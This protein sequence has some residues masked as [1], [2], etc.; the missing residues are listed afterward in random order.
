EAAINSQIYGGRPPCVDCGYC[1]GFGCPNHAKGSP[2]VTTLRSALLSGRCQLRFNAM[3]SRLVNDGGHVSAVEYFDGSGALQRARAGA[4]L[5]AAGPIE[6]PRLS[7]LAPT[8]SGGVLGNSSDQVG[9]NLM[10]HFQTN[11]N[12]FTPQRIHGQRGRAVSHGITDFRGVEPGGAE[13]RIV[14]VDGTP[15]VFLGGICEFGGP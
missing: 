15:G 4:Y 9:R 14:D 12:G 8:P 7:F 5:L 11:V 6:P 1:S 3:V 13:L 10:C 2:A